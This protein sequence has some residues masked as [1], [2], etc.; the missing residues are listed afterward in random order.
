MYDFAADSVP[1][2]HLGYREVIT[3]VSVAY[4]A[5]AHS[6]DSKH[7]KIIVKKIHVD[8]TVKFLKEVAESLDLEVFKLEEE[9]KRVILP[10][11]VEG[12]IADLDET[13]LKILDLIKVHPKNS[14]ELAEE[15]DTTPRTIKRKYAVLR[16]HELIKTTPGQGVSLTARG[17]NFFRQY[18]GD[19]VTKNVTSK[20]EQ[21]TENVPLSLEKLSEIKKWIF[22]R[23]KD[24]A[25]SASELANFIKAQGFDPQKIVEKFKDEGLL[26][27][28]PEPNKWG[29]SEPSRK[30]PK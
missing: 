30:R 19:K 9:G 16:K 1:I 7:E 21:V 24:G 23:R 14:G 20:G 28:I 6:T 3:R 8:K 27:S 13:A 10:T 12:I 4:A 25:V 11:E 17:V 15:L 18:L 5:L 22:E 2:V 26:F 29:V